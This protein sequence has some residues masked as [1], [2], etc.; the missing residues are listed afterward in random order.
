M[1][2]R[3]R[4]LTG[5]DLPSYRILRSEMLK[6]SPHAFGLTPTE[7]AAESIDSLQRRLGCP[8]KRSAAWVLGG[9]IETRLVGCVAVS[10]APHTKASHIASLWSLYV[11]PEARSHG[12]GRALVREAIGHA[13]VDPRIRRLELC[14]STA[15]QHAIALYTSLGFER[16]GTQPDAL[17][18]D[19][20]F[21]AEHRMG[22]SL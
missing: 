22:V 12:L 13:K 4:P 11:V 19:G 6:L 3:I 1:H 18:V 20:V 2:M 5:N 14:V 15:S 16:W 9:F 21:Y 17:Q 10:R 7:E 8:I